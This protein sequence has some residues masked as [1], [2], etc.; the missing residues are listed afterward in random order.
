MIY[1]FGALIDRNIGAYLSK[2][3]QIIDFDLLET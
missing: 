3:L 2:F 1:A